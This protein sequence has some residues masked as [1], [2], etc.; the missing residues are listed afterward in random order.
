VLGGGGEVAP[1][2]GAR[3]V[4]GQG[5]SVA[6]AR[7]GQ[8]RA[9]QD[10]LEGGGGTTAHTVTSTPTLGIDAEPVR[11]QEAVRGRSRRDGARGIFGSSALIKRLKFR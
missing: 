4:G 2:A 11:G 9:L 7:E 6:G 8:L 1:A 10:V 3:R 5:Q